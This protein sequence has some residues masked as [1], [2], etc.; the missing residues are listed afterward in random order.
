MEGKMKSGLKSKVFENFSKIAGSINNSE[1][2][3][4]KKQG[5]RVLGYTCSF[6]PE[7]LFIAA[8][9]MPF[10]IRGTGS[11]NADMADDY[12]EA[13]N[14][15]SFVRHC[16][17]KVL[18]GEYNFID[19]A[20]IG[21]GCDANRHVLDNWKQSPI[22]TPFLH[23]ILF[24][25]ATGELMAH[26]FRDQLADL[27][28]GLEEHFGVQITDQKL[29][30]AIKQ[31][32]ETRYLQR[33]LYDFRKAD[34]PPISGAETVAV[35][36]AGSSMP[37][38]KYNADLKILLD[39]LRGV[40]VPKVNY[41]AR[42]MIVGPGHD[43]TSMCVI[44]EGLGGLVAADLTC[45]GGKVI[46]GSIKESGPDPLQAIADYQVLDRPFCPKNLG[47]HPLISKEVF[48][49]IKDFKVDGVIGQNFLCCDTWGGELYILNEELKEAGIPMLR[50]EREYISDSTGQMQTRVQA[51][52]ETISGG[53][54]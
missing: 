27:K 5:G 8:G 40:K 4:W 26:Y 11:L 18:S 37:K 42:L 10:R 35:I 20:V 31:C 9:L 23:R 53:A 1:V 46:F 14:T 25:H 33:E 2:D 22:K 29:R 36:V 32:N 52:I 13:A 15:C 43:D 17:N 45:F 48:E 30:D 28:A 38:E 34:N 44:V 19:G 51:F 49:K 47:A 12:F 7:E 50:I 3:N 6:V 16:F 41:K 24:P 21:G 54:Q 39:E